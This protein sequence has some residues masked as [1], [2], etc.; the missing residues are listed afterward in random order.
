LAA[1]VEK[2]ENDAG[3]SDMLS[4]ILKGARLKLCL[5]FHPVRGHRLILSRDP[6]RELSPH[7]KRDLS[8]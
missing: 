4:A 2:I 5:T 3:L 8:F 7:V 6:H 1:Y